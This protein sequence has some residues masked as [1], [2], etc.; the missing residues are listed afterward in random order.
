MVWRKLTQL[1]G[2]KDTSGDAPKDKTALKI[3]RK[4][5]ARFRKLLDSNAALADL[6]A[7]MNIKLRGTSLFG[8]SYV[9]Q[10]GLQAVKLARKMAASLQGMSPGKHSGLDKALDR[11][12]NEIFEVIGEEVGCHGLCRNLTIG[13]PLINLSMVDW[14]G[15]KCANLGEMLNM[16]EIPVPRGFAITVTAFR[17]F[18]AHGDLE[19]RIQQRLARIQADDRDSL[20]AILEEIRTIV[21]QAELPE[22]LSQSIRQALASTFGDERVR[23]AVRSSAQAEDGEKSFAG[24]FLSELG[25]GREQV[26]DSYRRV[27]ASLF[28]PGATLYRLHQGIPLSETAMAVACLEMVEAE[29]SGVAYSHD[30]V[31]LMNETLVIN[32]IWGLGSYLVDG[33]VNPDLW[34]FTREEKPELVR[35]RT[36]TKSRMLRPGPD[37]KPEDTPVPPELQRTL[38]LS[39]DDARKLAG[40]VMRLDAH[41][42]CYQDVEWSKTRDGDIIFLQSRPLDIR[43]GGSTAPKSPLLPQYPLLFDGGDIASPGVGHGPVVMPKTPEDLLHF[44]SG[45]ILVAAHSNSSYAT[46]MDKAQA[47][48]AETGGITGHM[49]TICREFHVPTLLN[50]PG[51]MQKLAPG[52][53]ITVDAFSGRV[54][55][56]TVEELL[57]LRLNLDPVR[58]QDTPVHS[59][60]RQAAQFILPLNLTDPSSVSF[61]PASCKT[62]HDIMRYCHEKSYHEMFTISDN[63]SEAGNVAMKFK[64]PLPIDLYIIDLDRGTTAQAGTGSVTAE[65]ITSAPLKAM[66]RGMLLPEVMFRKP[67][68]INMGGFISVM[69]Q[70]MGNPQGGDARFGDKSYAIISDRYMNF[71]SRVGYHYSVLDAYC[72]A[73]VSKNY[74]SFSFQGGAAG[75]TRRLRRI[76]AIALVLEDLGFTVDIQGDMVK[77][78]F[79]KH[80]KESIEE[81]L[82]QLGRLLQVTRQMDMLMAGEESVARFREDFKNGIYR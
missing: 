5:Y 49:A 82:D 15:G 34:V 63:A 55:Q 52:M 78:R 1:F 33:Q 9:H 22:S 31:D 8:L 7:D 12:E 70:Q 72:G 2:K 57:P 59:L 81:R 53:E 48:L 17:E 16:A 69:G 23:L 21:E 30:P 26:E 35:R 51:L 60:L 18:M 39:E 46:V 43:A 75:E 77:A 14:V 13:F 67:R 40:L 11:I 41:Y 29:A 65:E 28:T 19:K 4:R 44:P 36:A 42:G 56:G 20:A 58:L 61:A 38:C 71:S 10:S 50:L 66:L 74:I 76:R 80:P 54:Y 24:Q 6:M 64:A 79:S 62:V 73:T 37:G 27:V 47:V 68:P 32:G 3:F 45:G 25:I